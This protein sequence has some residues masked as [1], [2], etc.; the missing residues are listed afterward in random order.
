M[1]KRR[2]SGKH[3][4]RNMCKKMTNEVAFGLWRIP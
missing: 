2:T 1:S 3:K 4:H